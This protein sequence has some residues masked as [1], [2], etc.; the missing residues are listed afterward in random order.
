MVDLKQI[1]VLHN[2]WEVEICKHMGPE[3]S[4]LDGRT[5]QKM[6]PAYDY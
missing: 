4:I 3:W 1:T 2:E 5:C 6:E